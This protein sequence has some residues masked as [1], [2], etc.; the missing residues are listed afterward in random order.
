M[1]LPCPP[2][3][4]SPASSC[5]VARDRVRSNRVQGQHLSISTCLINIP[6]PIVGGAKLTFGC[7]NVIVSSIPASLGS[8]STRCFSYEALCF[9][10]S[11]ALSVMVLGFVKARIA[12]VGVGWRRARRARLGL[13]RM[14]DML[15]ICK[16][17]RWIDDGGESLQRMLFNLEK[18]EKQS[19]LS[20][21]RNNLMAAAFPVRTRKTLICAGS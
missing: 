21:K 16:D 3:R 2:S 8:T 20:F 13:H 11:S 9:C 19:I 15:Q 4:G 14:K 10:S 6:L 5:Y 12:N 1:D 18:I 17:I 7:S